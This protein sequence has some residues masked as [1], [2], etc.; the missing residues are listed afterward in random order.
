MNLSRYIASRITFQQNKSF[1]KVI[2]NIGI[3]A[4]A[5]SVAVLIIAT[6]LFKGFKTEI[7]QKVYGFWGH[8]H[9]SD[10]N[11]KRTFETIPFR[12]DST[13]VEKI[14]EIESIEYQIPN[15][16]GTENVTYTKGTTKGGIKAIYPFIVTPALVDTKTEFEGLLLRGLNKEFPVASFEKFMKEGR[17]IDYHS[18]AAM[19]EIVVSSIT[20]KRL[21]LKIDD[22][23]I[24]SFFVG[25]NQ[26][27]KKL[28]VVGVYST[29]IEEYDKQFAMVD[30]HMLQNALQWGN[31][32]VAGLEVLVDNLS[33]AD[34]LNEYIYVEELPSRLYSET[35]REKFPNIFDWL[36]IQNVNERVLFILMAIVSIITMI[37]TY[38]IL[39]LER[40]HIIG[41]LKSLG[42]TNQ[43]VVRIF[44]YCAGF[45]IIRGI[46]IGNILGLGICFIQKYFRIIKLEEKNYLLD[47]APIVFD[48]WMYF[49]INIGI[50]LIT[51]IFL[52]I[53]SF[54]IS[55]ITPSKILRFG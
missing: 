5:L 55:K 46:I 35:V 9:I 54:L 42:A 18:E 36:D 1:T 33:D 47:Y 23:L 41:V 7:S 29:G 12:Y 26:L 27:R 52:L 20:L 31:D 49:F 38:L 2:I 32:Q 25:T 10:A 13:M 3:V 22:E 30:L 24:I 39:I 8:I 4:V 34:V 44:L 48:W 17:L 15:K 50:I 28:K 53:P 16:L 14:R 11:V 19:K 51:L 40:T 37:T 45:I 43:A 6:S 21:G